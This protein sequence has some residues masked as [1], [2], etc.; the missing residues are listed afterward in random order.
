M[1]KLPSGAMPPSLTPPPWPPMPPPQLPAMPPP[2]PGTGSTS[3]HTYLAPVP[4]GPINPSVYPRADKSVGVAYLLW[5]FFGVLG[6]HHFYLGK[7][8]RGIGYLLTFAWL[9]IGLWIDLFTLPGQLR[10]VNAKRRAGS[11]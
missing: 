6:V 5:L 10:S 11:R 8:G 2:V 7:I 1:D 9:T 3:R 4:A